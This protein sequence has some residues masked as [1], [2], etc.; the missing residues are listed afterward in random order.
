[1]AGQACSDEC[2]CRW[3][4]F[5]RSWECDGQGDADSSFSREEVC[6]VETKQTWK[7]A[8]PMAPRRCCGC[9]FLRSK[10]LRRHWEEKHVQGVGV[11]A[12]GYRFFS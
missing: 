7:G 12:D 10:D 5:K 2:D 1:M 8:D 3:M 6:S 11:C 4:S 9:I